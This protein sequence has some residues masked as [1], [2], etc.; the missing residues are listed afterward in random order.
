MSRLLRPERP[1]PSTRHILLA[2]H[3]TPGSESSGDERLGARQNS[4]LFAVSRLTCDSAHGLSDAACFGTDASHDY[5]GNQ[6]GNT[7][8]RWPHFRAISR[9]DVLVY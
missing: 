2:S 6:R 8:S 3:V 7:D 5:V 4:V 9:S 1:L